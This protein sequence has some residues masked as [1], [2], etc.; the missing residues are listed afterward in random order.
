MS[1]DKIVNNDTLVDI[2]EIKNACARKIQNDKGEEDYLEGYKVFL[3]YFNPEN[4][5]LDINAPIEGKWNALALATYFGKNEEVTYLLKLGADPTVRLEKN[6]T[7]LHAA[8]A[9]GKEYICYS[10]LKYKSVVDP[11]TK[12]TISPLIDLQCD[13]GTTALMRAS[14]AGRFDIVKVMLPFNPMI[15]LRDKDGKSCIDYCKETESYD[16]IRYIN[17]YHLNQTLP[18]KAEGEYV[19]KKVTKI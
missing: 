13:R 7:V 14:E 5:L 2:N 19:A 12:K 15:S 16:I 4:K 6:L 8:A 9:Q 11:K 10:L 18:H 17:N 3:K 1:E